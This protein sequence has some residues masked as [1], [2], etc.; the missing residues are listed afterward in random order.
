MR[1]MRLT[2]MNLPKLTLLGSG[3]TEM[4]IETIQLQKYHLLNSYACEM[5]REEKAGENFR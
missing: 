4:W 5:D 2:E 3:N 1:K